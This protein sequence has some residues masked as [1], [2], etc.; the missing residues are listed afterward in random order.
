MD[1]DIKEHMAQFYYFEK[2]QDSLSNKALSPGLEDIC[3]GPIDVVGLISWLTLQVRNGMFDIGEEDRQAV[4]D[5]GFGGTLRNATDEQLSGL[6]TF[7]LGAT[8]TLAMQR[9]ESLEGAENMTPRMKI[10]KIITRLKSIEE[11]PEETCGL[12]LAD[13]MKFAIK[14]TGNLPEA[15]EMTLA[16]FGEVPKDYSSEVAAFCMGTQFGAIASALP[17]AQ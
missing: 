12:P 15:E 1:I 10:R 13:F 14:I 11:G 3:T 17:D 5:L 9:Q 4:R 7:F 8:F 6:F 16:H 2:V